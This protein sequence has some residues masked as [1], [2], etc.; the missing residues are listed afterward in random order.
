M[1]V[2]I[3]IKDSDGSIKVRRLAEHTE[4]LPV[5]GYTF[6]G[7][8]DEATLPSREF[9][10]CWRKSG[11]AVVVDAVLKVAEEARRAARGGRP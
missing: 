3:Y 2:G 1:K 9:R 8:V 4:Y 11:E 10:V 5:E 6:Q 7:E